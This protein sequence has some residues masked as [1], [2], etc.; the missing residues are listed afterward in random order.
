MITVSISGVDGV[1]QTL[2][3]IIPN[4][5]RAVLELADVVRNAHREVLKEYQKLVLVDNEL[6][7][8][9]S[10][11]SFELGTELFDVTAHD[12]HVSVDCTGCSKPKH[13]GW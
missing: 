4:S 5:E 3:R 1:Q 11:Q 10:G 2:A 13:Y 6:G 8:A 7:N 9:V 12:G